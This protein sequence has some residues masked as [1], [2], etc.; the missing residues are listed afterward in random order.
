MCASHQ[1]TFSKAL[2]TG[3]CDQELKGFNLLRFS[4]NTLCKLLE[5]QCLGAIRAKEDNVFL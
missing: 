3:V 1:L 4:L 2:D 5:L